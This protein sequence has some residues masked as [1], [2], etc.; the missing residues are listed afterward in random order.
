[1]E[2]PITLQIEEFKKTIAETIQSSNLPA[3]LLDYIFRDFYSEIHLLNQSKS[4]QD[5]ISYKASLKP[6]TEQEEEH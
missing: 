2:K 4:E 3:F 5:K 1:M 6:K